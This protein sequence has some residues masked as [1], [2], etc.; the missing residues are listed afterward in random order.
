[1]VIPNWRW[2][3]RNKFPIDACLSGI[4]PISACQLGIHSEMTHANQEYSQLAP[5]NP[6]WNSQLAYANLELF[7]V[8]AHQMGIHSQTTRVNW[9]YSLVNLSE[10]GS[11]VSSWPGRGRF[12]PELSILMRPSLLLLFPIEGHLTFPRKINGWRISDSEI[13]GFQLEYLVPK[14]TFSM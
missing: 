10:R 8:S 2:L 12:S 14:T 6:E 3:F 1:M 5:V 9:E 13:S 4:F 7:P 11:I